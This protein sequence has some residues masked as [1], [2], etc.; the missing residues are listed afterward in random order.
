MPATSSV[1]TTSTAATTTLPTGAPGTCSSDVLA[2]HEA[3][4]AAAAGTSH[5]TF[6]LVDQGPRACTLDGYP[7]VTF[8]GG[9]GRGGAGAGSKL[10]V[11]DIE[12]GSAP[13]RVTL[14]SGTGASFVLSVSEVPV[15]GA[16]CTRV[17]SLRVVPPGG[18]AALRMPTAFQA[19]GGAVGVYAVTGGS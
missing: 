5:L 4:V 13:H 2:L 16:G 15:N 7:T 6:D 19:C 1:P 14:S 18:G 8:F 10:A 12:L 3:G 17:A 9:S 11:R